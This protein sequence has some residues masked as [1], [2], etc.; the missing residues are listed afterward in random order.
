MKQSAKVLGVAALGA[1]FAAAGASTASAA[2]ALPDPTQAVGSLTQG[3]PVAGLAGNLPGATEAMGAGQNAVTGG[4]SAAQPAVG[5]T[6][7]ADA[8]PVS[9]LLGGLPT[10]GL[11]TGALPVL[12]G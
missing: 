6:L 9:G 10:G 8:D 5:K 2:P 11:P 7:P 12:G 3:L 1:A 4:L